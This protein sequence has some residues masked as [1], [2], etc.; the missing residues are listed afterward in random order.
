MVAVSWVLQKKLLWNKTI[1]F[2]KYNYFS[3]DR[4]MYVDCNNV[5][6]LSPTRIWGHCQRA[7]LAVLLLHHSSLRWHCSSIYVPPC[8]EYR[9]HYFEF[10][11]T[12]R[13]FLLH[14]RACTKRCWFVCIQTIHVA[15][16]LY[17]FTHSELK[18]L[19][20]NHT[21]TAFWSSGK[22]FSGTPGWIYIISDD[23][24]PGIFFT[25]SI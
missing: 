4:D 13:C 21:K 14:L 12:I 11:F 24:F 8:R 7:T 16:E 2:K 5:Y 25:T 15:G 23:L 6:Q 20:P 19:S 10:D 22:N 18:I 1:Y 17:V 9:D 3:F